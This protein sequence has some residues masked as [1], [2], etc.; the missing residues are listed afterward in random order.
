MERLRYETGCQ[1]Q[2]EGPLIFRKASIVSVRRLK[3]II[4]KA[5]MRLPIAPRMPE[6]VFFHL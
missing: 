1:R 5:K 6:T 2:A 3:Y 4:E